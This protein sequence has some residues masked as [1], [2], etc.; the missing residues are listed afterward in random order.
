MRTCNPELTSALVDGEL[1]GSRLLEARGHV[2]DCPDCQALIASAEA[3]RG[4]LRGAA[5]DVPA[6]LDLRRRIEERLGAESQRMAISRI[7]PRRFWQG[8]VSG[9]GASLLAASLAA[10]MLLP[11]D[12]DRLAGA[13]ADA[14]VG[15]LMSSRTIEIASSSRHTVRPWFA[16]RVP[17]APPAP[18]LSA[19]GFPLSGGRTAWVAGQPMA[20]VV[21]R[22]GP[23]EIDLF[24]WRRSE[25]PFPAEQDRRG[26]RLVFWGKGDLGF[27]AVSDTDPAE[28]TRFATLFRANPE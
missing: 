21:Y 28:L 8:A 24:V 20:V 11:P 2:R 17:V 10:V 12:P 19:Q 3:A 18:D 7:G 27:A 13:L 1:T 16:G 6:S 4:A 9:V 14:H 23:H 22:H 26:Y 15:A 5:A 25:S